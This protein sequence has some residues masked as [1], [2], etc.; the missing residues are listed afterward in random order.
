MSKKKNICGYCGKVHSRGI[1]KCWQKLA[2][3]KK[4]EKNSKG[5]GNKLSMILTHVLALEDTKKGTKFDSN[6]DLEGERLD[7]LGKARGQQDEDK[8]SIE[9]VSKI[10]LRNH[11][12]YKNEYQ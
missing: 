2:D 8:T 5:D 4:K 9:M 7:V 1:V 11:K 3:N 6:L 10:K 12:K